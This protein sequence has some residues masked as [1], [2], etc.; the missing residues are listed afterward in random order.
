[1]PTLESREENNI[2]TYSAKNEVV[3]KEQV[4]VSSLKQLQS[5]LNRE[6]SL[7]PKNEKRESK[8]LKKGGHEMK[9]MILVLIWV[10]LFQSIAFAGL[11]F[12]RILKEDGKSLA[13]TKVIFEGIETT[14]NAFGGYKV[15]LKDGERELL[16]VINGEEYTSE[17]IRIY[18]PETKQNWLI[19]KKKKRLRKIR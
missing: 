1:L 11:L 3:Y 14:T 17:K 2:R 12:G 6:D 18:S 8:R 9:K 10:F 7:M 5:S 15:E 4:S 13:K 19:D 16:V